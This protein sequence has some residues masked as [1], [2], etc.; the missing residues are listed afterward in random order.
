MN[1]INLLLKSKN[2]NFI[3]V[4]APEHALS[5]GN[6]Y[7]NNRY[8]EFKCLKK[9]LAEIMPYYDFQIITKYNTAPISFNNKFFKSPIHVR[10]EITLLIAERIFLNKNKDFGYYI[11]KENVDRVLSEEDQ[12]FFNYYK[13]NKAKVDE[14]ATLPQLMKHKVYV[15]KEIIE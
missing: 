5:I 13:K 4:L 6:I 10:P 2:I 9:K 12:L 11:T 8:E 15:K 3:F 7:Y 1:E 14:F